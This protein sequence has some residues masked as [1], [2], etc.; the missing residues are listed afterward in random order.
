MRTLYVVWVE[1]DVLVKPK[2]NPELST[3]FASVTPYGV[4]KTIFPVELIVMSPPAVVPLP[5]LMIT[6]PPFP[7]DEDPADIAT[8]PPVPELLDPTSRL[9]PPAFP[10]LAVPVEIDTEPEIDEPAPL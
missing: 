7:D 4:V 10:A 1:A 8:V 6:S 3:P 9:I 2:Y 5:L